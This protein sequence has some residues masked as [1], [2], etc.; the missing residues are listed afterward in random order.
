MS[1][2]DE[3]LRTEIDGILRDY[4]VPMDDRGLVI[5]KIEGSVDGVL[6]AEREAFGRELDVLRDQ[7][8]TDRRK[9][10][11][12]LSSMRE[13]AV[14]GLDGIDGRL[15]D[16]YEEGLRDGLKTVADYRPGLFQVI[17]IVAVAGVVGYLAFRCFWRK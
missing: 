9:V 14:S 17:G 2:I 5:D 8:S 3:D 15:D 7:V 4:N 13:Q 6:S 16:A 1:V 10:M 12:E 11:G